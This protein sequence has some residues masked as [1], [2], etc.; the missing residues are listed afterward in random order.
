MQCSPFTDT[1]APQTPRVHVPVSS[2]EALERI[3]TASSS[4]R[5]L[6][7]RPFS[8]K[9]PPY[10]YPNSPTPPSSSPTPPQEAK[11][12]TPRTP[13]SNGAP[14]RG[15]AGV[16]AVPRPPPQERHA[17]LAPPPLRLPPAPL[18]AR[19]HL[20]NLLHRPRHPLPLLLHHRLPQRPRPGRPRRPA[21]PALRR[22]VLRQ[23]ALLRLPLERRRRRRERTRRRDRRGHPEEQ[24]RQADPR[25]EGDLW[26]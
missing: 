16:A 21:H 24:P 2:T 22:Q 23:G 26:I 11:P 8:Y 25:R 3:S 4:V 19:L 17:H 10:K 1:W 12:R 6:P 5:Y 14:E 13:P 7:I 9:C 15:G 18:L 20:P